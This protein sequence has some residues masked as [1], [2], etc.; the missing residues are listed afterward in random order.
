MLLYRNFLLHTIMQI[1][2][3]LVQH[4]P[5]LQSPCI[6]V[7]WDVFVLLTPAVESSKQIHSSERQTS[8]IRNDHPAPCPSSSPL[9]AGSFEG[10]AY[11]RASASCDTTGPR[12]LRRGVLSRRGLIFKAS[13]HLSFSSLTFSWHPRVQPGVAPSSTCRD[14]RVSKEKEMTSAHPT[15]PAESRESHDHSPEIIWQ[16]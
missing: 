13:G 14:K 10:K 2:S 4:T 15:N 12:T 7:D 16:I 9:K 3:F 6:E 8:G 1:Y 5:E 11:V